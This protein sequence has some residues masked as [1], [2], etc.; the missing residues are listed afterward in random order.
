M[1]T[2][3]NVDFYL[4]ETTS[5]AEGGRSI[6]QC[7]EKIFLQGKKIYINVETQAMAKWLDDLLWTFRDVSFVPHGL[8]TNETLLAAPIQ[9]GYGAIPTETYEVL[10]NL[11][12]T[13]PDYFVNFA[14]IIEIIPNDEAL[15]AAGRE[16]Y[17]FYRDRNCQVRAIHPSSAVDFGA[18]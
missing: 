10:V 17:K 6:C 7:L 18:N 1:A 13:V 11:T 14:T 15:K 3:N 5:F 9:I 12:N 2:N 16:K 8:V 4:L